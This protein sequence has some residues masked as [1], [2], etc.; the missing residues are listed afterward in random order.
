MVSIGATMWCRLEKKRAQYEKA[1]KASK[2][3]ATSAASRLS[4]LLSQ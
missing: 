2:E 1:K 3:G 4:S